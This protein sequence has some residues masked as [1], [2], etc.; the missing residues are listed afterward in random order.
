MMIC[1]DLGAALRTYHQKVVEPHHDTIEAALEGDRALRTQALQRGGI[2]RLLACYWPMMRWRSPVLEMNC[3]LPPV[4]IYPLLSDQ[5]EVP[6]K[7]PV[8]LI[9][10]TRTAILQT[11][12]AGRTV[13][14]IAQRVGISVP[15]TNPISTYSATA[16]CS[17]ATGRA[18]RSCTC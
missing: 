2:D 16:G 14:D 11:M 13:Q 9:G 17:P 4:L 3:E 15:A 5:P 8:A 1:A 10:A 18:R 6:E 7:P 12:S